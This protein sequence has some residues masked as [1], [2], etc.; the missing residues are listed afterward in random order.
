MARPWIE[1]GGDGLQ[2]QKV[3]A[4]IMDKQSWT[5]DKGWFCIL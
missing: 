1:D 3:A 4:Y 5:A 2:I